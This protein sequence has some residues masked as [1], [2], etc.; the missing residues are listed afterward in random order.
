MITIIIQMI[1]V[2]MMMILASSHDKYYC[3]HEAT[4][5][6]VHVIIITGVDILYGLSLKIRIQH[7]MNNNAII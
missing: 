6:L 4:F 7:I 1:V 3:H 2:M 5:V